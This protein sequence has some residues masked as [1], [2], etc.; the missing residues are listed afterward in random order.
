MAHAHEQEIDSAVWDV[1]RG[2]YPLMVTGV[3]EFKPLAEIKRQLFQPAVKRTPKTPAEI[4][5]EM[6]RVVAVYEKAR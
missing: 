5:A 3:I 1:W 6:A 2:L 4:E